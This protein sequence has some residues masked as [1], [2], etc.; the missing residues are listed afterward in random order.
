MRSC[1]DFA[2]DVTALIE[3]RLPVSQRMSMWIHFTI[4]SSCRAY[5]K[6]MQLVQQM[7]AD[8]KPSTEPS[9]DTVD[10]LVGLFRREQADQE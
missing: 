1:E 2:D 5:M 4:C 7:A 6:Q 9:E 8:L 10:E 3:G